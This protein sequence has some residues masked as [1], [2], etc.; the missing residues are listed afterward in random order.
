MKVSLTLFSCLFVFFIGCSTLA[1]PFSGSSVDSR[2]T[3]Y[4]AHGHL[5][6]DEWVI[7][8]QLY[9]YEHRN[10]VERLT[11]RM[12]R[13]RYNLTPK[14]ADRFR[15]RIRGLVA[16][17]ES[18]EI[19]SFTFDDDPDNE[20][21]YLLDENG[22]RV[23]TNLN[24]FARGIIRISEDRA[25]EL[26][27]AQE[28]TNGWLNLT[29][30]SGHRGDG[31]VQL[32]EP[33]GLS[34]ISDIDDTIKIT[35]IHAGARI[36]VRNTFFKEYNA[37]PGMLNM[38]KQWEDIASFHYV[39]GSPWQL[40]N[41]LRNFLI[42]DTGFP[43][44]TFHMKSVRKNLLNIGSWRD[45]R[46]LATN[47][48]ITYDQKISQISELMETFPQRRFILIGDS[49]EMDPEVYSIIRENYPDQVHEI[50]IRDVVNARNLQPERLEGM[51]IIIAR[52]IE[53]G[54]SQFGS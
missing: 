6:G 31:K 21:F 8:I 38:Y 32:I 20:E 34:I 9:A 42:D 46:E 41:T 27:D 37:A 25:A 18:R 45:L 35:E 50:I 4:N 30:A 11:T 48:F 13:S 26:K 40:Y 52:T 49:G 7:P 19:I 53:P 17:S 28:S 23:R 54:L 39:S 3:F 47:E 44:G 10:S 16:D 29:A 22:N 24:G 43:N 2:V 33:E 14:E 15:N 5:D 36:V 1:G 51:R 12:A